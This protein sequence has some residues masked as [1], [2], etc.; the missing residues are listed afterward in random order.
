MILSMEYNWDFYTDFQFFTGQFSSREKYRKRRRNEARSAR[1]S[2]T[3]RMENDG[4]IIITENEIRTTVP[5]V[6]RRTTWDRRSTVIVG[7]RGQTDFS[8]LVLFPSY[9]E[10]RRR[11]RRRPIHSPRRQLRRG[12]AARMSRI[13]AKTIRKKGGGA[14]AKLDRPDLSSLSIPLLRFKQPFHSF[15]TSCVTREYILSTEWF[16]PI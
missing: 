3:R 15:S 6:R 1:N 8:L 13:P 10:R 12:D 7:A 4:W 5:P 11:R 16:P 2:S 9:V 14:R